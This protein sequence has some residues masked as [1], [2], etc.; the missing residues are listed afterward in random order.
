MTFSIPADGHYVI[1]NA[2]VPVSVLGDPASGDL[3]KVNIT[4]GDGMIAA[5]GAS[6]SATLPQQIDMR[7]DIVL[8]AFVDL[9]THLDKGHIWA[10][11]ENPDGTWLG[12]LMAVGA[13]CA[14]SV[15][16]HLIVV[17]LG[18]VVAMRYDRGLIP[19]ARP[20]MQAGE[21]HV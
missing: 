4:I 5:I 12:A 16:Y 7:G 11:R 17:V 2:S 13:F 9:H 8:P 19:E 3:A 6:G 1:A 21:I 10:R 14:L 18:L 20:F 15:F